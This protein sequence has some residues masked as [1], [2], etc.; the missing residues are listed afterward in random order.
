MYLHVSFAHLGS[1]GVITVHFA[2]VT[3][4]ERHG[5][6][7]VRYGSGYKLA[8]HLRDIRQETLSNGAHVLRTDFFL[9]NT[10]SKMTKRS[11]PA[12]ALHTF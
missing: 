12:T 6:D 4:Q 2:L 9:S 10:Y 5:E 7:V 8:Q 1:P 11:F 3:V